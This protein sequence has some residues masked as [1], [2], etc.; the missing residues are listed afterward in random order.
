MTD[1]YC[2]NWMQNRS[3][4]LWLRNYL[5]NNMEIIGYNIQL[6][7]LLDIAHILVIGLC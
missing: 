3:T 2:N 1:G 6:N 5:Q 4:I 7:K